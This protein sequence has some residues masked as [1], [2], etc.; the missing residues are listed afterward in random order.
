MS[1]D[2]L[3]LLGGVLLPLSFAPYDYPALAV[4]A[5]ALLFF[6]WQG[7]TPG[8]AFL[9]GYLF[10]L[11]LFGLGASWVYISMHRYGGASVVEA[12]GLTALFTLFWALYPAVAGGLA[13]RLGGG[14]VLQA[15]GVFP[16]AWMLAEWLRS[17]FPTGFPWLQIGYSQLDTPLGGLA[18]LFGSYGV[19]WGVALVAGL[20]LTLFQH[21]GVP[22]RVLAVALMA[23]LGLCGVLDRVR[24]TEPAGEP[25]PVAL[26]QG[27]IPQDLKWQPEQQRA[28]LDLYQGMT[29][30]HW[31][32]RL[33]VWPETA[34][35]A[36]YQ[37]VAGTYLA[38]LAKE[39][40]QHGT[41]IL[42]GLPYYDVGRDRYYNAIVS[43]GKAPGFYFKRHLV[44]F[45]EYVPLRPVFG[46][47]LDILQIPLSDFGSGGTDQKPLAAAGYPLAAS[48]CYE[49]VFGQESLL[50][51]P[52]A[53]YL[54][55]VTNDAWFGDSAAPHQHAQMA[56]MR[57]L[58]TGRWMLRA[59][60]SGVTAIITDR[61]AFA[62][63]APLFERA[64]VAGT[65]VPMRGR[66]PYVLWGD[67]PVVVGLALM[68]VVVTWRSRKLA[69]AN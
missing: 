61:G 6:A 4:A 8:R 63:T 33:I 19:G 66:T 21:K 58:E 23:L 44:P 46:W 1:R 40:G 24:W 36:F 38:D 5:L 56:R 25:F 52:E 42:L 39:A 26:M 43:L 13:R 37:Q 67:A 30:R 17:W 60:N 69:H 50:H 65:V 29:R 45:G 64:E 35:P 7:A 62:A 20:G 68:F 16:A 51:L 48:I 14:P 59:T 9:R 10:G 41:D 27:N 12:G 55:N 28:T 2:F 11:G 54:V 31:D 3:A 22:R 57:S 18:P 34:V 15:V 47:V 32:A 53:A 49:D